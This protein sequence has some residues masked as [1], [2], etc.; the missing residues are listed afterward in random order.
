[1]VQRYVAMWGKAGMHV[2]FG[3]GEDDGAGVDGP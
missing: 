3:E 1:M 2:Q